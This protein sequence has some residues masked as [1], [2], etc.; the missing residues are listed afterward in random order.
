VNAGFNEAAPK[1]ASFPAEG[2]EPE[3]DFQ[4]HPI[5]PAISIV[6]TTPARTGI[7]R[8]DAP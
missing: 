5:N 7:R 8:M 1:T 3:G 4:P 6:T 2:W